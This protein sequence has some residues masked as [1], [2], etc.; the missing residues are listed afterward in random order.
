MNNRW[1]NVHNKNWDIMQ[2]KKK[3]TAGLSVVVLPPAE[4]CFQWWLCPL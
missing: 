3:Q 4:A 1:T 2:G